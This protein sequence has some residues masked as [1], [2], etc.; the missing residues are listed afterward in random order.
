MTRISIDDVE[1]GIS[2]LLLPPPFHG[3]SF[4]LPNL[5]LPVEAFNGRESDLCGGLAWES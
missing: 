3:F 2:R 4:L 5:E 1:H